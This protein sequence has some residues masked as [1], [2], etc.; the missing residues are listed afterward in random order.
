M[1]DM[2]ISD[3]LIELLYH[4]G[5]LSMFVLALYIL[6]KSFTSGLFPSVLGFMV[7]MFGGVYLGTVVKDLYR[8][9]VLREEYKIG[10]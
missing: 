8:V 9:L 7:L 5:G 6:Y 2:K 3:I 4:I 1:F 10:L